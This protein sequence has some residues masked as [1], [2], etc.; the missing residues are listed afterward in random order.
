M[1]VEDMLSK[2]KALEAAQPC[3]ACGN[4]EWEAQARLVSVPTVVDDRINP[5]EGLVC[6]A[7]LCKV[8]GYARFHSANFLEQH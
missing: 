8:C 3:A 6:V 7:L 1:T 2:L 4:D 5:M